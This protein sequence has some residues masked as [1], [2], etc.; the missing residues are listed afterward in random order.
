[1]N[2][3]ASE[4]KCIVFAAGGHAKVVLEAIVASGVATPI[5]FVDDDPRRQGTTVLGLP[6]K[7]E[8]WLADAARAER[9]T[10]ALGVGDNFIR[11]GMAARCAA[12]GVSLLTVVHPSAL[13]SP[14]ARIGAGVVLSPRAVVHTDAW[15][16][17]GTIVNT[18]GI[19]EHDVIVGEYAHVSPNAVLAGGSRLGALSHLG[20]G[21]VVIDDVVV[22]SGCIVGAGS[23]VTRSLPDDVVA[24]GSPA[25][26][27]R[28]RVVA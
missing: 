18:G 11:K 20:A 4:T 8:R 22:G 9:L 26:V 24:Y 16:G 21:S 23:V 17:E 14:S 6:V 27:K 19:V 10:A 12:L 13:I 15:V 3:K 28:K 7:N 1:M 25:R 5:A 2:V